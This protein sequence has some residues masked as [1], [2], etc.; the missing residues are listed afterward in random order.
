MKSDLDT[1]LLFVEPTGKCSSNPTID[2]ITCKLAGAWLLRETSRNGWRGVHTADCGRCSDNTEHW[3]LARRSGLLGGLHLLVTHSLCL[4]YVAHHRD[5]IPEAELVKIARLDADMIS[6]QEAERLVAHS[7]LGSSHRLFPI[8]HS[9]LT[10][11]NTY[12]F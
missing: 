1:H 3:L 5:E 12:N 11:P 6:A 8:C 7:L 2:D 10:H 9:S 4:H